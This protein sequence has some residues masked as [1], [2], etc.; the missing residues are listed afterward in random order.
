MRI[1]DFLR[2]KLV[3]K[4]V[5]PIELADYVEPSSCTSHACME[6]R[7]SGKICY[8]H[9]QFDDPGLGMRFGYYFMAEGSGSPGMSPNPLAATVMESITE[10]LLDAPI[11]ELARRYIGQ[12]NHECEGAIQTAFLQAHRIIKELSAGTGAVTITGAFFRGGTITVGCVGGNRLYWMN[13]NSIQTL[14]KEHVLIH[15]MPP[16]NTGIYRA[17]GHLG[18]QTIDVSTHK[19]MEDGY[20]LLCTWRLWESVS[21]DNLRDTVMT[22]A[23]LENACTR[24][25]K[26][27]WNPLEDRELALIVASYSKPTRKISPNN[28]TLPH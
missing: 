22:S 4:K 20:L 13:R 16:H 12:S 18:P 6:S 14:T 1:L 23:T 26:K 5:A 2:R 19:D 11:E 24:L 10:S 25:L 28:Q 9:A 15:M 17:L 27:A 21:E 8:L 7:P 3:R